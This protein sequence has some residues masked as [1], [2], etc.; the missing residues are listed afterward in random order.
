MIFSN[1]NISE[2]YMFVSNENK[3]IEL[4]YTVLDTQKSLNSSFL[5]KKCN[6]VK[7]LS[8]FYCNFV[9]L[10]YQSKM[11]HNLFFFKYIALHL[12]L[13]QRC[14]EGNSQVFSDGRGRCDNKR[15]L[16]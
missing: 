5:K 7:L 13:G 3:T 14:F 4:I 8:M 2:G 16:L 15:Q 12:F 10:M 11:F 1:A 9:F 6:A